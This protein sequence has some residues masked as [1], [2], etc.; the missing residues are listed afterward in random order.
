MQESALYGY[1]GVAKQTIITMSKSSNFFGQP[2]YGQLIKSLDREKIVEIS[3]KHGGEKYVKSFDGYT[4][5]LTMLYAVI[6]RFDSLREIETSMTAEVRKLRHV[7][8]ETVPRR[9]TLSDAN[10]R[11]SEK[12]FEEVYRD[13]YAANKDILSSD[14]RRNGTEEWIKQLRIIDSTTITLFS[15]AIFEGVG[16]HP[17]TGKKKGG[18][19][20]HS[21]IHANEGVPCDVQFTSAATNDSF[22]LALSHYSHNDIVAL[23]RAYINYAK[24]E[25]LTDRGVV[26]VTKMKKNLSYEILVDC[27]YQNS[28]G[29]MEYREQVVVF[30]KNGINHIARI[31]TYVDIKKGKK[32]KLI[33]LL[34]NDFDMQLQTIVAIYRRRWQIES[35]FK[36]IKQNFPL[37]YSYGE[38]ANAIKIQ[39]WVTLIAN[40]LLSVLQ[41]TLQR[42]WS[43]S[44]LATIVRIILMYYLNLEKFLN[45]PDADLKIMLVEAA[46][47]PP[48][49]AENC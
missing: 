29:H 46:E 4:H 47:S 17:K 3:R 34:T 20:V 19:K 18:I 11:R 31:I 30:R 26:Y 33:S 41:S 7:G 44:G 35:L 2:I 45:Q 32:P 39:I 8:I 21:V 48:K 14:S 42:R 37:R 25:E 36:K 10:A 22:M 38:S 16:R 49:D 5:L 9:S 28:Q 1:F 15:N 27:V 13:L 6:Q 43:F 12:F 23:D 24:F 40:L